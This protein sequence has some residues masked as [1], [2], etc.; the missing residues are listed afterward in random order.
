MKSVTT[1]NMQNIPLTE[2]LNVIWRKIVF[3]QTNVIKKKKKKNGEELTGRFG[4]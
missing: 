4:F 2:L 3:A 1:L